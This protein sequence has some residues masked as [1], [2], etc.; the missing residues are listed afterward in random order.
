MKSKILLTSSFLAVFC[1]LALPFS[2]KAAITVGNVSSS[3]DH[4]GA[5]SR[6]W[7]HTH[8]AG[9]DGVLIVT[10]STFGTG[11]AMTATFNGESMT[12][13]GQARIGSQE[14]VIVFVLFNPSVTTA[15]IVFT[16]P[17]GGDG[18]CAGLSAYGVSNSVD[19]SNITTIG[20][21]VYPMT[22]SASAS[23]PSSLVVSIFQSVVSPNVSV[24]GSQ[25][26]FGLGCGNDGNNYCLSSYSLSSSAG[27]QTH[28]YNNGA[29]SADTGAIGM[30]ILKESGQSTLPPPYASSTS[31]FIT[32]R[33]LN[34]AGGN[35]ANSF[36]SSTTFRLLG[37]GG[38]TAIGS[39]TSSTFGIESGFLRNL[40]KGP[41]PIYTQMHYHWRNDDGSETTATSKTSGSQDAVLSTLDESTGVRLRL[42]I[43]N[44]GG[45]RLAY[46]QQQLRLEYG[47]KSTTCAAI[48]SWTDVGGVGGDWDM[49]SSANLTEGGNT[50][51][52]AVATGGV[53]NENATFVAS[54]G[55]IRDTTSQTSSVPV[56]SDSY[57]ELEYSIQ[58]LTAA[59]DN[60]T[61]C[62]R[63]TNA[64]SATNYAYRVYPEATISS[65]LSLTFVV[66][67]A[68]QAFSAV[69]PG[70]LAATSSILTVK[71]TNPTGFIATVERSDATGTMSSG[72]F[73]IPDKTAWVPGVATTTPG[74]ATA[75]TTQPLT[76][77]FRVRQTGTDVPNYA[78]S[79]WGTADTTASALFAGFPSTASTIVNRSTPAAAT[80]TSYVLY[81]LNVPVTQQTGTYSGDI[82]YTVTANP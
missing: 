61:Y 66:D 82:I 9:S 63:V 12:E 55:G 46:A 31:F 41:A 6:T 58:A 62:F 79:W 81:N 8:A 1:A 38:Q 15:N 48:S 26:E 11:G 16:I 32:H 35:P 27:T 70:T 42:L 67:G 77:Q 7:A 71:T 50:T 53:A 39:S 44:E 47:L 34:I 64:G 4:F 49:F 76:L 72:A 68:S 56:S 18:V 52:I 75:S 25:T 17:D 74:N 29:A 14:G 36:S 20:S 51:N 69:T 30:I 23:S 45:T 13:I 65:P 22:V 28:T 3:G 40:Y 19:A 59:T 37:A 21:A 78:S 24:P 33:M 80:T 73:Y 60:G 2:A 43:S 54:N 10:C 5:S 57:I